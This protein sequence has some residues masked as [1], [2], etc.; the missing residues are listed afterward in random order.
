[1]PPEDLMKAPNFAILFLITGV[2]ST[3][4]Y[5]QNPRPTGF[6]ANTVADSTTSLPPAVFA[7]DYN[8]DG[9][10][11]LA[12]AYE[13]FGG[14]CSQGEVVILLGNGDGTFRAGATYKTNA[15]VASWITGGD[16]NGD[17]KLDLA[18]SNNNCQFVPCPEG[19]VSVFLGRGDGTFSGPT[20]FNT[21]PEPNYIVAADLNGDGKL[22]LITTNNC[23][24]NC[25]GA[26]AEAVSVLLG[27]GNGGFQAHIDTEL[28][29]QQYAYWA[30]VGDLNGDGIPDLATADYCVFGCVP[31]NGTMSVLFGNGNGTFRP[32]GD[33]TSV[34]GASST[35]IG[36]F[37][38]DGKLDIAA[39]NYT[40]TVAIYLGDGTGSFAPPV[41]YAVGPSPW[42][43]TLGDFNNDGKTDLATTNFGNLG[44]YS[45]SVS[46]LL[47]R[48]DG[49]FTGRVDY[50]TGTAP[51]SIITGDFNRDG[52]L[53][54]AN[55]NLNDR[56]VSVL[57]QT[58]VKVGPTKLSFAT[59]VV[60]TP[61]ASK[62]IAITN[63]GTGTLHFS[64]VTLGGAN[65]ADFQL[66]NQCGATLDPGKSCA[67][68]LTFVPALQGSRTGTVII[69]DDAPGGQQTI[70]MLAE[71][72]ALSVSPKTL[73]FGVVKV[74][75]T[76]DPKLVTLTN[77][78]SESVDMKSFAVTGTNRKDFSETNNCPQFLK[79]NMSCTVSV[80]FT[81]SLAGKESATLKIDQNGGG[82]FMQVPM[83]GA[84][85]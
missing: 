3:L 4:A 16:F 85:N 69:A 5:A 73:S 70:P 47:G 82:P 74:G 20:N 11:D 43:V 51:Q 17:G 9:I 83:F 1:M 32:G 53:D 25:N 78:S 66:N 62:T 67:L 80:T 22:D 61:S 77:H 50:P 65:P 2:L 55:T 8:A 31:V 48:G 84:G 27:D 81:P 12:V 40:G 39:P 58:K 28:H 75:S 54:L 18:V 29:K 19:V 15:R 33:Y 14:D 24:S 71:G 60:G 49:S 37:N 42:S 56:T 64:G 7:G 10:A 38:G 44:I 72:Q 34:G 79:L 6:F 21:G 52:M 76:S 30:A 35:A 13:C 36:D 59:T 23:V 45:G 41:S 68:D 26:P 46:V 57:L 63:L